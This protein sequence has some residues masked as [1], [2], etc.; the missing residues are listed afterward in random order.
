MNAIEAVS[1]SKVLDVNATEAVE[2]EVVTTS[3]YGRCSFPAPG[4]A[5]KTAREKATDLIGTEVNQQAEIDELLQEAFP[6]PNMSMAFSV[7]A[8]NAAA[9]S[10]GMSLYR[11]LGGLFA[12]SMPY[13]LVKVASD[14]ADYFVIPVG[15]SSFARAIACSISV[16]REL[17]ASMPADPDTIDTLNRLV[18]IT[19]RASN[20]FGFDVKIGVSFKA[21]RQAHQGLRFHVQGSEAAKERLQYI[22]SL[23]SDYGL[24]YIEDA[25]GEAEREF[26]HRLSDEL[27]AKCLIAAVSRLNHDVISSHE[28]NNGKR[29]NLALITLTRT[30]SSVFDTYA[31]A[32]AHNHACAVLTDN[33]TTCEASP[34]HLAVALSASFIKLNVGGRQSAAKTNELL[35][36]EHEL[37]DGKSYRMA[38]KP[39]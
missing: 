10:L 39:I 22:L 23:A 9:A 35:R 12:N 26:Q 11:Y 32:R 34:A 20:L 13:P 7:A 4:D 2:V 21:S 28:T 5:I 17:N 18:L 33:S 6:L 27:G 38:D 8:A 19:E 14:D 15:A 25:F 30:I 1:V 24:Y 37:F 36:I 29:T 3:G 16:F 31:R